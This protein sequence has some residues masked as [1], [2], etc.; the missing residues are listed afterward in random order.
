MLAGVGEGVPVVKACAVPCKAR[1]SAVAALAGVGV[2]VTTMGVTQLDGNG[3]GMPNL[4]ARAVPATDSVAA[5]K[6]DSGVGVA[7]IST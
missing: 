3:V 6:I 5:A 2:E 7:V 4:W 1:A